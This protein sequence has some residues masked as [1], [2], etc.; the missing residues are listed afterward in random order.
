MTTG[1]RLS[2]ARLAAYFAA[3]LAVLSALYARGFLGLQSD[4]L[5]YYSYA[6]SLVWDRDIDLKNQFDHPLPPPASGTVA[7]G[8]YFLDPSTGRAFSLFNSGTGILMTPLIFLGRAIDGLG[9]GP[10]RD[11]YSKYYQWYAGYASVLST[12]LALTL[13]LAI[14]GRYFS[15]G[16]AAAVPLIFLGGTNWLFYAV[17]FAG[18]S[19]SFALFLTAFLCWAFLR[20][21]DRKNSSSAALFGLAGG[22]LFST[23]N[24]GLVVFGLLGVLLAVDHIRNRKSLSLAKITANAAA[25]ASAFLLGAAPQ[26][27]AL[28]YLHGSPFRT[29]VAAA[30][31]A[32]LPFGFMEASP[33]RAMSLANL[34]YLSS[35]LFNL[36]NGLFS[37]HPLFLA[38]VLG[39]VLLRPRDGRFRAL[40]LAMT[41]SVF[42]FWFADAAYYDNWF[43]RAAGSGFGH[44]RFLDFLPFF[45]FGA[46]LALEKARARPWSRHALH[47]LYA[48]LFSAG[49]K[50]LHGFLFDPTGLYAGRSSW[51]G[52]QGYLLGD[53]RTF[54]LWA[55]A[56]LV[57]FV[58]LGRNSRLPAKESAVSW[59]KPMV[60]ALF[61]LAA[62][63]PA[64]L[65]KRSEAWERQRFLPKR[66]F[67]LMYG[68]A[69][70]ADLRGR[71]WGWPDGQKR[72]MRGGVA[73]LRLPAPLGRGDLL[74]FRLIPRFPAAV[75]A[76]LEVRAGAEFLGRARLEAGDRIYSFPVS[77]DFRSPKSLMIKIEADG[78][79]SPP[80]PVHFIEGR[81]VLREVESPPF[82]RI[83]VPDEDH[84]SAEG[85]AVIEGWALADRGIARVFAAVGPEDAPLAEAEFFEGTRPDVERV[86]VLYPG[87]KRSAWRMTIDRPRAAGDGTR[88][89]RL[90]VVAEDTAGR[91]A[92]LGKKTVVWRD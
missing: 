26:F 27:L 70:Y 38:G 24:F 47:F 18:W 62:I 3:I 15:L 33:F 14:L 48:V 37:V 6:V 92:V 8:N 88:I 49:L 42:V 67:F 16:T 58:V 60:I 85:R 31:R 72:A 54:V 23:R 75:E 89:L 5:H 30:A 81:V 90:R 10:P 22:L 74:L 76:W 73:R 79:E 4:A 61:G 82:G 35:N 17:V 41:A 39:A 66:G 71:W 46:A 12:A 63:G 19:H 7:N 83:D 65:I 59:R 50:L 20:H 43:Q 34:P 55:A 53:W 44:R 91:R 56:S 9:G 2:R 21:G 80:G 11:P 32:S 86:Y 64:V 87:L 36:E 77:K 1:G 52:L 13:L 69:P 29:S 57:L 40:V 51:A 28:A 45:V 84:L 68:H 78:A 25:S